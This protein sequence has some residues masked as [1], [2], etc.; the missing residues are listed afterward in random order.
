MKAVMQV[1]AD[2]APKLNLAEQP[3]VENLQPDKA[4]RFLT[5]NRL[6]FCVLVVDVNTVDDAYSNKLQQTYKELLETAANEVGK[7][8]CIKRAVRRRFG[9]LRNVLF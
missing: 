4:K 1:F 3:A 9:Y 2:I 7:I 5:R 6:N 8:V